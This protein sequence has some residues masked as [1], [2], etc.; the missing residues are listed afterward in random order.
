MTPLRPDPEAQSVQS[1]KAPASHAD[2]PETSRDAALAK[3]RGG[4]LESD[5][6]VALSLVRRFPG[7]TVKDLVAIHAGG[8]PSDFERERQRIGRRM[9]ELADAG[10]IHARGKSEGCQCWWPGPAPKESQQQNLFNSPK[11][12]TWD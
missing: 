7:R 10:L 2:D 12:R 3:M 1:F 9:S 8:L 11:M 6:A 4:S 5:R